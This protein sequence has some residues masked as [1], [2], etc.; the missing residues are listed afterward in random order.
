MEKKKNPRF[1]LIIFVLLAIGLFAAYFMFGFVIPQTPARLARPSAMLIKGVSLWSWVVSLPLKIPNNPHSLASLLVALT[2]ITFALYGLALY[3]TRRLIPSRG[4]LMLAILPA[5]AFLFLSVFALPNQNTDIFN[6]M[7]RG[8]LAAIYNKNPYL[9]AADDIPSDPVYPYAGHNYTD[10]PEWWKGPLWTMIEIGLAKFTG[11]NVV[12][13]LFVYRIIFAFT[14]LVNLFFISVI[15]KKINPHHLLTGLVLY[16][17]NPITVVLGQGKGDVFIVFFLLLAILFLVFGRRN[18][19]VLPLSLSVLIKLTTLPL[20][21]AYFLTYLR[22]NRWREY[23]LLVILFV[24][25]AVVFYIHFDLGRSLTFQPI[26]VILMAGESAPDFLRSLLRVTF[27]GLILVIGFKRNRDD[28]QIISG[29]LLL[30]L[31]FSIFLVDYGKAW[32]LLT[33]LVLAGLIPNLR[34]LSLTY[35]VS[36]WGFL[37]YNWYS[38]FN[39]EFPAPDMISFPNNMV[40]FVV[41][42][43]V[44]I[45]SAAWVVI[46][47]LRKRHIIDYHMLANWTK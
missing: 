8:R 20:A 21:A 42:I 33:L 16:A 38:S 12:T 44:L 27:I 37:I 2:V 5:C 29:W 30:A 13:N 14:N 39:L 3:I 46:R 15:L 18:I 1:L 34:T 6:Y 11:D 31:F 40:Y 17:W 28:K 47:I 41:P 45:A 10:E 36:C 22:R 24:I 19:A 25:T 9:V 7:L 43:I 26:P 4:S 23:L 32:Y 35:P